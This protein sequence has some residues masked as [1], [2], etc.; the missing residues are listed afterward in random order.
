MAANVKFENDRIT[1]NAT[2]HGVYDEAVRALFFASVCSDEFHLKC[3]QSLGIVSYLLFI[4]FC[5]FNLFTI[6]YTYIY[7]SHI[8]T[9]TDFKDNTPPCQNNKRRIFNDK[10]G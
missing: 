4:I 8:V 6:I 2:L 1:S 5:Y 10:L 9:I 3:Y 7:S